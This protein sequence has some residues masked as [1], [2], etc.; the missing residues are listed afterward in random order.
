MAR[1]ASKQ[2]RLSVWLRLRQD[3]NGKAKRAKVDFEDNLVNVEGEEE[4]HQEAND[5]SYLDVLPNELLLM[6]IRLL[7][8]A[9]ILA[10][11]E[12]HQRSNTVIANDRVLK[13]HLKQPIDL[14]NLAATE[15]QVHQDIINL[16]PLIEYLQQEFRYL[17]VIQ[18]YRGLRRKEVATS[19]FFGKS[20]LEDKTAFLLKFAAKRYEYNRHHVFVVVAKTN[21]EGR[22]LAQALSDAKHDAF[23]MP[24]WPSTEAAARVANAGRKFF[25][26]VD[27]ISPNFHYTSMRSIVCFKTQISSLIHGGLQALN[28]G[29]VHFYVDIKS[30][31]E[32]HRAKQVAN[33][34]SFF[35]QKPRLAHAMVISKAFYKH[36]HDHNALV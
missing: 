14:L 27:R 15:P 3:C 6:I 2:E 16:P 17:R 32:L 20:N 10:L 26:V 12:A 7:N 18:E 22:A 34:L 5:Q 30:L 25:L 33:H 29:S 21:K 1:V 24:T 8:N 28:P 31:D 11:Q 35:C 23:F 9:D 36:L 19:F 4:V 13:L